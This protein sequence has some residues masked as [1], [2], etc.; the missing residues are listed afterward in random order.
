MHQCIEILCLLV[1]L[2]LLASQNVFLCVEI[3]HIF[4][5]QMMLSLEILYQRTRTVPDLLVLITYYIAF[6]TNRSEARVGQHSKLVLVK[7][8]PQEEWLNLFQM[9]LPSFFIDSV[10]WPLSASPTSW[11]WFRLICFPDIVL[12]VQ[13][14][15]FERSFYNMRDSKQI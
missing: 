1:R 11:L 2:T 15:V 8:Y 4:N 6:W 14:Q 9:S 5:L 7:S 3:F 13:K 12:F 10:R